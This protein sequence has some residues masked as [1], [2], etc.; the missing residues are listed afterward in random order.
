MPRTATRIDPS[1]WET[2]SR[3][4]D[5]ESRMFLSHR[6]TP[7]GLL[8]GPRYRGRPRVGRR[9]S[10]NAPGVVETTF[11][12]RPDPILSRIHA[13]FRGNRD[14]HCHL[15]Y[16]PHGWFL[17]I[18]PRHLSLV[19]RS[20]CVQARIGGRT[21]TS[22]RLYGRRTQACIATTDLV[23]PFNDVMHDLIAHL[24]ALDGDMRN[25]RL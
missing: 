7:L 22:L 24:T 18:E 15:L 21:R 4:A 12:S 10:R 8:R 2:T 5:W 19:P 23:Q 14:W 6:S 25:G 13:D 9:A 3:F 1:F 20:S 11:S 16:D 17:Q